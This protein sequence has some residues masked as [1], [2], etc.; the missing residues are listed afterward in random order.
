MLHDLLPRAVKAGL[1]F[2]AILLPKD[3]FAKLSTQDTIFRLDH[4]QLRQFDD[5][6]KAQAWL[7]RMG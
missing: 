2:E 6:E 5:S 4:Y 3:T 7:K 1:E